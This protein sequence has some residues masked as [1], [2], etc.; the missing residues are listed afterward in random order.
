MKELRCLVRFVDALGPL[1]KDIRGEHQLETMAPTAATAAEFTDMPSP[2]LNTVAA[3]DAAPVAAKPDKLKAHFKHLWY[4]FY[5]GQYLYSRSG[6]QR[7]WRV[8]QCTGGRSYLSTDGSH[9][10]VDGPG[11]QKYSPLF[12]DCYHIDFN[13]KRFGPVHHQFKIPPFEHARDVTVLEVVPMEYVDKSDKLLE[14]LTQRGQ[15]FIDATRVCHR[16]FVGRTLVWT[17]NGTRLPNLHAEDVDSPVMV[18][19]DRTL[20][21][22]PTWTPEFGIP[23]LAEQDGRETREMTLHEDVVCNDSGHCMDLGCCQNE[24]IVSDSEWDRQRLK[25][26]I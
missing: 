4:L 23:S 13:G 3:P 11:V 18:D 21:F 5:P 16:Y 20:Q 22:N 1:I 8:I 14:H 2:T 9:D 24:N 26:S 12:L 6:H 10:R 17:P 25:S 7:V 15:D 19:F